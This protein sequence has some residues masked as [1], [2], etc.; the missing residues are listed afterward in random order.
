MPGL[1]TPAD[2]Q[3]RGSSLGDETPWLLALLFS[4]P[5]RRLWPLASFVLGLL[6]VI[7]YAIVAAAAAGVYLSW[8]TPWNYQPKE[9]APMVASTMVLLP[10]TGAYVAVLL[11]L[12]LIGSCRLPLTIRLMMVYA[13]LYI[14]LSAMLGSS[15]QSTRS[16]HVLCATSFCLGG[17]LQQHLGGWSATSWNRAVMSRSKFAIKDM[18]D[19]TA[20]VALTLGIMSLESRSVSLGAY[21]C[22][23]PACCVFA[24]IGMHVWARLMSLSD[25]SS[26]IVSGSG[27]WLAGNI[28]LACLIWLVFAIS[29]DETSQYVQGLVTAVLVVLV[30]HW[31]TEIPIRW[32]RACGW[33]FVRQSI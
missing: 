12:H 18:L 30:A 3:P 27:F 22:M 19:I 23:V 16:F 13:I 11:A 14:S 8:N 33:K 20:A 9:I 29:V 26:D 24:L 28:S 15:Q 10:L 1:P 6:G 25:D 2:S 17:F 7:A 32:L 5:H 21:L 4:G 31:W